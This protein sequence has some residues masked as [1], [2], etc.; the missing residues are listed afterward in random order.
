MVFWCTVKSWGK[1]STDSRL[2]TL[3][4]LWQIICSWFNTTYELVLWKCQLLWT[5]FLMQ[6]FTLLTNQLLQILA[7]PLFISESTGSPSTSPTSY[8]FFGEPK[9]GSAGERGASTSLEAIENIMS[10]SIVINSMISSMKG[11][12]YMY[13]VTCYM[14]CGSSWRSLLSL[15][16]QTQ[17]NQVHKEGSKQTQPRPSPSKVKSISTIRYCNSSGRFRGSSFGSVKPP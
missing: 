11:M 9:C 6:E 17:S 15:I 12:M 14:L 8:G 13:K 7:L 1:L 4:H 3:A 5:P 10:P 16:R 2:P